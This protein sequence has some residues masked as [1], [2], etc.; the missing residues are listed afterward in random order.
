MQRP[1]PPSRCA[2]PRRRVTRAAV[3]APTSRVWGAAVG[4]AKKMGG[5]APQRRGDRGPLL[6]VCVGAGAS[7]VGG[8]AP[9]CRLRA[10]Q[11]PNQ[12]IWRGRCRQSAVPRV[13]AQARV[14]C[15]HQ[16]RAAVGGMRECVAPPAR[17]CRRATFF[18]RHPVYKNGLEDAVAGTARGKHDQWGVFCGSN[19]ARHPPPD[20][21]DAVTWQ[22]K[23]ATFQ[24]LEHVLAFRG[25]P[26][27]VIKDVRLNENLRPPGSST[28]PFWMTRRFQ[29]RRLL[30]QIIKFSSCQRKPPP[31]VREETGDADFNLAGNLVP[32]HRH[33]SDK[34]R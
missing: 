30:Y 32:G 8:R 11:T 2:A 19:G 16:Q 6:C 27:T 26:G 31:G 17:G 22:V 21:H 4:R 1:R 10:S 28:C 3:A 9:S 14:A 12:G 20:Q 24:P 33:V 34:R 5:A 15:G 13:V 29:S 23:H 25:S 18:G 7:G